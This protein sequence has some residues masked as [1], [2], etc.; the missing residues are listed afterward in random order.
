[1]TNSNNRSSYTF[2]QKLSII[3]IWEKYNSLSYIKTYPHL[4]REL[5]LDI[6]SSTFYDFIKNKDS[7]KRVTSTGLKRSKV[8][9]LS[10]IKEEL[11]DEILDAEK[12]G[13]YLNYEI[14]AHI[15]SLLY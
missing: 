4:K 5:K 2:E 9:K 8:T 15:A 7:L 14:I 13:V 3:Q 1:M 6:A 12:N 11:E 10:F